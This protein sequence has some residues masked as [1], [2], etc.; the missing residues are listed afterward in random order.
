VI[1]DP[2]SY[3]DVGMLN[4]LK[5]T[6]FKAWEKLDIDLAPLTLLFGTNSSG[7]SSILHALL[8]LKQTAASYD[9]NQH[10]N[11]GGNERDYIS[12]GSYRDL[13]FGHEADERINVELHW[14]SQQ[15][16]EF[17]T[18]QLIENPHIR[19]FVRWRQLSDNVVIERLSY[20][21]ED[22]I[23]LRMER[24][25]DQYSYE[26]PRGLKDTRGR[27]PY[28]PPP[29]SCYAIPAFI[30]DHYVD[31][32]P[33]EFNLQFEAFMRRLYYLGPLRRYPQREYRW[34]GSAPSEVGKEGEFAVEALIASQRRNPGV[35]TRKSKSK[36]PTLIESVAIW[37]KRLELVQ[38]FEI[39]AIDP[40]NRYYRTAV[41]TSES[42]I[43]SSIL[44][45]GFGVSQVLPVI[46]LLF[47][48]PEHSIVLLE[49]PELHLHPSAQ[50]HL[51]D[52]FI[53]VIKT[54]HLQLIV[55][56]HSEH[57]VR[58]LQRRLAEQA[59][60][61]QDLRMYFCTKE[62]QGSQI[63]VIQSDLFGQ[64][65]NWPENFFGDITGD[66]EEM[67]YAALDRFRHAR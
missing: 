64:I 59:I 39:N 54:R 46:T 66:L 13:V 23:F 6:H 3:E 10:I 60:V 33:L 9:R 45:V 11:F 15:K 53:E 28:L 62:T 43:P 30:A 42:R 24:K 5:L 50:A 44:D 37:L 40:D 47:F 4:K 57:L 12:F 38:D 63:E 52:L 41:T 29:E 2:A 16:G 48:V 36:A 55:E 26:A 20:E 19:Y 17:R 8:L 58:R 51:A 18:H 34:T 22:S 31:F 25:Q 35:S 21:T 67:T 7:K 14:Q 27:N 56:S 32:N 1:A 49:Q 65:E 61:P